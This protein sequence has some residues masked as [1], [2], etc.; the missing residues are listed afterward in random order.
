MADEKRCI[1]P[2]LYIMLIQLGLVKVEVNTSASTAPQESSNLEVKAELKS[3]VSFKSR[4]LRL[5]VPAYHSSEKYKVPRKQPLL[6]KLHAD[7]RASFETA[8]WDSYL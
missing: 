4:I 8:C 5:S 7:L 1:S 2:S 3:S 6:S